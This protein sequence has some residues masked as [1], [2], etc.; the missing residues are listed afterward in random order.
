M[1]VRLYMDHHVSRAITVGLR[2]RE[3]DVLTA[4]EDDAAKLDD[5][6]LLDR[7]GARGRVLFSQDEDL[8]AEAAR[9][10]TEG[11][12]FRG[13]IYARQSRVPIG[14]CVS[15]LELIARVAQPGDLLNRVVFLPL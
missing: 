1:P 7:A 5:A 14:V 12:P 10:Q 2:R 15:D 13:V 3:V 11:V 9:R 4:A 8:L 6:S